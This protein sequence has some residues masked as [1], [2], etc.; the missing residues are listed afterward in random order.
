MIK[1]GFAAEA[2]N[3]RYCLSG[4][5]RASAW[6]GGGFGATADEKYYR[7]SI[8]ISAGGVRIVRYRTIPI[9]LYTLRALGVLRSK[10]NSTK[11]RN[12]IHVETNIPVFYPCRANT[13]IGMKLDVA[14]RD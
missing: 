3:T 14:L 2:I 7:G 10:W 13:I 6:E 9:V 8:Y 1:V 11:N 12:C 5:G 4:T